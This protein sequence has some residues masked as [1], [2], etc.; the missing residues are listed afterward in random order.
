LEMVG[1][2]AQGAALNGVKFNHDR[3]LP[4]SWKK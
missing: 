1:G 4:V 3:I 2:G